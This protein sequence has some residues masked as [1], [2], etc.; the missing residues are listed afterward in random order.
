VATV[1][2]LRPDPQPTECQVEIVHDHNDVSDVH[3]MSTTEIPHS[4]PTQVDVRLGL[5]QKKPHASHRPSP[6]LSPP[7]FFI[8]R[9]ATPAS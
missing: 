6:D 8:D 4:D 2:S 7:F 5:G 3:V 1:P 9:N